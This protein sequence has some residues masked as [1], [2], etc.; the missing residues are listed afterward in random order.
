MTALHAP[1]PLAI[2]TGFLGSGKT[3]FVS[4]LLRDPDMAD[5]M[6]VVNEFGALGLDH[7]LIKAAT[8]AVILL[9]NGCLCC[10]IRQDLVQTLRDVHRSW[11]TGALPEFGRVII[12]TTGLAEPA[13]LVASVGSHPL[14]AEAFALQ[15]IT[16]L[17]DAEHGIARAAR[18]VTSRNQICVADRLILSKCDLVDA[19]TVEV[20]RRR[21]AALN[22]LAPIARNDEAVAADSLFSRVTLRAG[23][24][25]VRLRCDA[26]ADHRAGISSVLLQPERPLSWPKFQVWLNALLERFGSRVMRVKGQLTFAEHPR[27]LI[28][29]AVHHT[30]YPVAEA[31]A[32][33]PD[34]LVIIF[35]GEVPERLDESFL[36][37]FSEKNGKKSSFF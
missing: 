35:E 37:L 10:S 30:F 29:Q 13:P 4:R 36:L 12:E 21:L 28:I 2:V 9:P 8:D 23:A 19:E 17:V 27:P 24:G 34:F 18:S 33:S 32:P 22:P 20:L 25:D 5:T 1:K 14:L 3:T 7:H 11:L 15:S 26:S 6:V 31:A 16:T